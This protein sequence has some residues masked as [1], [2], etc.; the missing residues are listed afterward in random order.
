M[1]DPSTENLSTDYTDYTDQEEVRGPVDV[2]ELFPKH[3]TAGSF[4]G[5]FR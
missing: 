3:C 5:P 2:L 1:P 4:F